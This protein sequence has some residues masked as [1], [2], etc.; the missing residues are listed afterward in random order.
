MF[1]EFMQGWDRNQ[2][3]SMMHVSPIAKTLICIILF[4]IRVNI[5]TRIN[6]MCCCVC[7]CYVL[8]VALH[9]AYRRALLLI[10]LLDLVLQDSNKSF[11]NVRYPSLFIEYHAKT[12]WLIY[13]KNRYPHL[14]TFCLVYGQTTPIFLPNVV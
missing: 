4:N 1:Q 12:N 7:V 14:P 13:L 3:I 2:H 5:L 8:F 10:L 9:L 11:C 6:Y